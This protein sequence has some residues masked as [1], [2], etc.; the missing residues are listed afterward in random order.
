MCALGHEQHRRAERVRQA[1]LEVA[2]QKLQKKREKEDADHQ[3]V[4]QERARKRAEEEHRQAM[5]QVTYTGHWMLF[6]AD[7]VWKF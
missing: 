5:E 1:E 3:R 7:N 6:C 2:L 4:R